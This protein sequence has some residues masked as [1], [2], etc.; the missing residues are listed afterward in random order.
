MTGQLIYRGPNLVNPPPLSKNVAGLPGKHTR[1][2]IHLDHSGEL[3]FNDLRKFGWIQV[4][5]KPLIPK[6]I[7]VLSKK[8]TPQLINALTRKTRKP[9]KVLLMDQD[10]IT[11]IGNIY[12]DEILWEAKIHPLS[13]VDRLENHQLKAIY[14][15]IRKVLQK[16]I[17]LGGTSI[18]DF[19]KLSGE[20][21]HFGE[22]RKVYRREKEKCYRCGTIIKRIK[23]GGRGTCF[24]PKCQRI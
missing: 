16:A 18:S 8:F 24:C 12:A 17:R 15:A 3:F 21:G 11:G 22:L 4:T 10:L 2:I 5:D 1:I 6:G 13:Q 14:K 19:R 20:K 9:I 23:I 7:D